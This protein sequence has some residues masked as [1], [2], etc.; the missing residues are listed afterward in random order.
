MTS[1]ASESGHSPGVPKLSALRSE[2][3]RR[4]TISTTIYFH[5]VKTQK[6]RNTYQE[7]HVGTLIQLLPAPLLPQLTLLSRRNHCCHECHHRLQVP[8]QLFDDLRELKIWGI[9]LRH[10]RLGGQD[11][12][13]LTCLAKASLA[14]PLVAIITLSGLTAGGLAKSTSKARLFFSRRFE[15]PAAET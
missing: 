12:R 10:T 4:N 2:K 8:G 3:Q 5:L 6:E 7:D 15:G 13:P 1:R 14:A 9:P 11:L